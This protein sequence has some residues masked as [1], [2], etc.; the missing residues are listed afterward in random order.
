MAHAWQEIEVGDNRITTQIHHPQR[1][2][3][4]RD[5]VRYATQQHEHAT[6]HAA[7]GL[8]RKR[9]EVEGAERALRD[10]EERLAKLEAD[11]G[12]FVL[13]APADGLMTSITL[14]PG[15][16]VGARQVVCEV[17]DPSKLV[18]R[19]N[20]TAEDL[21]VLEGGAAINLAAPEAPDAGL[22][23]QISEL[24]FIGAASGEA[25]HFPAVIA[26]A[27]GADRLRVGMRCSARAEKVL[28]NVLSI[29]STGVKREHGRAW[30]TLRGAG[31]DE[32]REI[33]TG[34]TSGDMVQV[35]SGI[36]AGESVVIKE[37]PKP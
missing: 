6:V 33:V 16:S 18:V 10:A 19:L 8:A 32:Q 29:P 20:L 11:R 31:G 25:T 22:G 21:R 7:I 28:A 13:L 4:A 12:T 14:E 5:E 37:A 30:V 1:D 17:L 2:R 27:R 15:D 24:A 3:D 35:V 26:L 9:M 23:G 34:A 36:S